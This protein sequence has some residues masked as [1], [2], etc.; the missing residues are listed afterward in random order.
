MCLVCSSKSLFLYFDGRLDASYDAVHQLTGP[1]HSFPFVVGNDGSCHQAL[2]FSGMVSN[3][4]FFNRSLDQKE[5]RSLLA[6]GFLDVKNDL[7]F[8]HLCLIQALLCHPSFAPFLRD[9][10]D[11]FQF[12]RVLFKGLFRKRTT[13]KMQ[14]VTLHLL[15]SVL[16]N[17]SADVIHMATDVS[18]GMDLHFVHKKH[19]FQNAEVFFRSLLTV[20]ELTPKTMLSSPIYLHDVDHLF[21][22]VSEV[23]ILLRF[24]IGSKEWCPILWQLM[25]HDLNSQVSQVISD[26]GRVSE[27]DPISCESYRTLRREVESLHSI[28]NERVEL[29]RKR[30]WEEHESSRR[31]G[32]DREAKPSLR[33]VRSEE[34]EP[35]PPSTANENAVCT[36]NT[37]FSKNSAVSPDE[38]VGVF[39]KAGQEDPKTQGNLYKILEIVIEDENGR[40]DGF[41]ASQNPKGSGVV[42]VEQEESKLETK[43]LMFDTDSLNQEEDMVRSDELLPEE[44]FFAID[45]QNSFPQDFVSA[46]E[47]FNENILSGNHEGIAQNPKPHSTPAESVYWSRLRVQRV[48]GDRWGKGQSCSRNG[49]GRI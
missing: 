6:R 28:R 5:I 46:E 3:V 17:L 34:S 7:L 14:R 21:A 38:E 44:S 10:A 32:P 16:P 2:C 45:E 49:R 39:Q 24:L 12:I 27:L 8:Q 37:D 9:Q 22:L 15:R 23:K 47:H 13:L 1:P 30:M 33:S 20:L 18:D 19:P 31:D 36:L 48:G 29:E 42:E 11:S 41:Q 43:P 40:E 25:S 26:F 35:I 4:Y